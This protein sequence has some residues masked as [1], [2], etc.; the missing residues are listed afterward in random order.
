MLESEQGTFKTLE[1][2]LKTLKSGKIYIQDVNRIKRTFK[3]TEE[4]KMFKNQEIENQMK[5][6]KR[7]YVLNVPRSRVKKK[8]RKISNREGNYQTA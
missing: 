1:E 3:T 8:K 5:R 7:I 2:C 4:K 6:F